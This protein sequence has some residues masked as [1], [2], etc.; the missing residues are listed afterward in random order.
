MVLKIE[1]FDY[2]SKTWRQVAVMGPGNPAGS[3][4]GVRQSQRQLY[5]FECGED[6]MHSAIYRSTRGIDVAEGNQ[7][8]VNTEGCELLRELAR[9]ESYILQVK[10]D[11]SPKE[12]KVRFTHI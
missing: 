12:R 8:I 2:D 7:R 1:T 10:T 6:D 4:S 11:S 5:L 3:L 9:G